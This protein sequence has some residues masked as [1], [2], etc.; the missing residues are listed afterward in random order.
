MSM[1]IALAPVAVQKAFDHV[2]SFFPDVV[3]VEYDEDCRWTFLNAAGIAPTFGEHDVDQEIL[4]DAA[5][6]QYNVSVPV[7]YIS[8]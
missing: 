7:K 6:A 5:D 1:N 4:E 2:R 3:S 8:E